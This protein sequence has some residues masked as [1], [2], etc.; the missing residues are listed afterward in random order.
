M[1][2]FEECIQSYRLGINNVVNSVEYV[3]FIEWSYSKYVYLDAN[4]RLDD[5]T[6]EIYNMTIFK[7]YRFEPCENLDRLP[8]I[9]KEISN[10]EVNIDSYLE[11]MEIALNKF[12]FDSFFYED[13]S[14]SFLIRSA[15]WQIS[16]KNYERTNINELL[17][18]MELPDFELNS[19][20]IKEFEEYLNVLNNG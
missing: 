16:Q 9:F 7:D 6:K 4:Y 3:K 5:R 17:K 1:N 14:V 11:K 15:F 18:M 2:F 8:E 20:R 12:V 10:I 19:V 13:L